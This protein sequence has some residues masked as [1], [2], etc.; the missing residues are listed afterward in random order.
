MAVVEEVPRVGEDGEAKPE[1]RRVPPD[2][3]GR[4]DFLDWGA[5]EVR[6]LA[7]GMTVLLGPNPVSL[8]LSSERAAREIADN[9]SM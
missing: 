2:P 8:S 7:T 6:V 4:G 1:G 5:E 9:R 3:P